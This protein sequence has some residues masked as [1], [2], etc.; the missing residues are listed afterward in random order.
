VI[1]YEDRMPQLYAAAD[2]LVSRAGA[3]TIAELSTIGVPAVVVPWPGAAENHQVDNAKVLT[4]HGA[5]I[6]VEQQDLHATDLLARIDRFIADPTLLAE[7]AQRARD[8]GALHRSGRLVE[9]IERVAAGGS[10]R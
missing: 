3:G 10:V 6:L 7:L 5:A 8:S 2:L 4:E 9:V 1:G